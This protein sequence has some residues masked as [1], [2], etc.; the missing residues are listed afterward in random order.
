M[1]D[2]KKANLWKPFSIWEDPIFIKIVIAC[3]FAPILI[4]LVILLLLK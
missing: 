1:T 3:V 4:I 2:E